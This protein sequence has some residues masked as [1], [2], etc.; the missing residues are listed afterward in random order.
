MIVPM[1]K[2]TILCLDVDRDQSLEELRELGVMHLNHVN[3]PAGETVDQ[4][5]AAYA[6]VDR[7]LKILPDEHHA[8]PSGKTAEETVDVITG[9]LAKKKEL[10]TELDSLFIE[11]KRMEP[12]GSFDP[13]LIAKLEEKGIKVK[14]CKLSAKEDVALPDDTA[15]HVIRDT[16]EGRYS[17]I[18]GQGDFQLP[19][20]EVRLPEKS[21]ADMQQKMATIEQKLAADSRDIHDLGGERKVVEQYQHVLRDQLSY[22]EARE[23]MGSDARIMFLQGFCPEDS[24]DRV[25]H[26][27]KE[28]GWGLAVDE[29][30]PEDNV[31]T[32]IRSPKWVKPIKTIFDITGILPGYDE[33]DVSPVFLIALSIF[34]AMLVGDAGYGALF[35]VL[36]I[37]ARR[38]MKNAPQYPFSFMVIMSLC[39][40]IWGVMTGT[41]FG[42]SKAGLPVPYIHWLGDESSSNNV[43]FLCFMIGTIHLSI[44]HLWSAWLLRKTPRA[45]AHVGWI[46]STI[47]M[48]FVACMFVLGH[49]LHPWAIPLFV[50]GLVL[51]VLFMTPPKQLKEKWFNHAML[52]LSIINNFTD[53]VS[54][55][56]LFA[57]GT[58]SYAVAS[59]FNQML[60]ITSED[61]IWMIP[62]KVIL[63]FL[64][65]GLNIALCG[66][67]ILVHGVRLNTLEYSAHMGLQWKGHQYAPFMRTAKSIKA[68]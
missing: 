23:G 31:P 52:P 35:L 68:E 13:A 24:M 67:G 25:R 14:L 42:M 2:L 4:A 46:L 18:V 36:T 17:A 10:Q 7:A 51:I 49:E 61:A 40:I 20:S 26:A 45:A 9:I 33:V 50:V 57:V 5:K 19:V 53:V 48:F 44:A 8:S 56:R 32:D 27:A 21:L 22:V 59:A 64:G 60:A 1:K 41:Y 16:K 38:K 11:A 63:L 28:H 29:P 37:F 39:T 54:Y 55:L 3:V 47:T 43:M 12:Y 66:L 15:L 6:R 30:G 34:F 62:L 58:A 65:H